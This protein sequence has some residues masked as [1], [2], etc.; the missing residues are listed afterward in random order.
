MV[1]RQGGCET[2]TAQVAWAVLAVA[3]RSPVRFVCFPQCLAAARMLARRGVPSR[4]HYGVRR[5]GGRLKTHTWLEAEGRILIGGEVMA[6]YAELA[7]Y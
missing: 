6:E 7:V 2:G 1:P 3:R 5:E 4:L